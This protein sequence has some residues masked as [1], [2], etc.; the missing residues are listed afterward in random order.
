MNYDKMTGENKLN[1][2]NLELVKTEKCTAC[3]KEVSGNY[4]PVCGK[5]T[6]ELQLKKLNRESFFNKLRKIFKNNEG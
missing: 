5:Y 3:G 2:D 4:C 1:Y 6:R